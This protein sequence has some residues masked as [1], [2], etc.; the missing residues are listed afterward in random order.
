MSNKISITEEELNNKEEKIKII[1]DEPQISSKSESN[2]H[3]H[4][5]KKISKHIKILLITLCIF[6][7]LFILGLIMISFL[8]NDPKSEN[9]ITINETVEQWCAKTRKQLNE[10][11]SHSDSNLRKRIEDAHLTVTVTM[12]EIKS[13]VATTLDG[14]D[15]S[16]NGENISS[17]TIIIEFRWDGFFQQGGYSILEMI[18]DVH[19]K[20][21]I[22]S[23]II[24]TNAAINFE[25]PTF[26]FNAGW[27]IGSFL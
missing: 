24:E 21:V 20:K 25:D 3:L 6:S 4:S 23:N 11:L 14:T 2:E 22:K 13:L 5:N 7:S 1:I 19:N 12:A 8:K 10:E 16:D 15:N 26:W 17:C 9:K 27:I 18:Y